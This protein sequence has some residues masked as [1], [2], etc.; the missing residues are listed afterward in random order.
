MRYVPRESSQLNWPEWLPTS[1][2]T[3]ESSELVVKVNSVDATE[4]IVSWSMHYK[5]SGG[6]YNCTLPLRLFHSAMRHYGFKEDAAQC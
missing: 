6:G 2:D 3:Y 5:Q 4:K 1:G